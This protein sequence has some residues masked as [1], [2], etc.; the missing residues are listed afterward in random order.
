MLSYIL[1]R[2]LP[3]AG[4]PFLDYYGANQ[5]IPVTQVINRAHFERRYYLYRTLGLFGYGSRSAPI[6]V[7][8][9][10]AGTGDNAVATSYF[11]PGMQI[12]FIDGN[13]ASY[14][15]IEEKIKSNI[16]PNTSS[17][18]CLDFVSADL[19]GHYKSYDL[20]ICEGTIPGQLKPK[21]F[22]AK[23]FAMAGEQG[24][25]CL[26]CADSFS[27][28]P[29]MLRRLYRPRL[30]KYK[31][32]E[33][34]KRGVQI[35]ETHL[36]A[37]PKMSRAPEDWVVDQII[38]PWMHENWE[39]SILDAIDVASACGFDF[40]GSSPSFLT[41][42]S[43][44][45]EVTETKNYWNRIASDAW[46]RKRIYS[47]SKSL[48]I[49][50]KDI[51][52]EAQLSLLMHELSRHVSRISTNDQHVYCES[53]YSSV[54]YILKEIR[55]VLLASSLRDELEEVIQAI[56]DFILAWPSIC[57]GDV[58]VDTNSFKTWWGRGQ[59]YVSFQRWINI[60][61]L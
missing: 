21:E 58:L 55:K 57:F 1:S 47:I 52:N 26:T 18:E 16:L 48:R 15:A 32:T 51:D 49:S 46:K 23:L 59:Q 41:D 5:I 17:L 36:D 13:Q 42:W 35:F 19:S 37:L 50:D 12:S 28:L 53:D 30:M 56:S 40:L 14:S 10:G 60:P 8:E 2:S 34:V 6:K 29:E 27:L 54:G 9:I 31:Y 20:V 43:W 61:V 33:A 11:M 22:A 39:F 44:Y 38:H 4:K 24:R 25:V 7:M 3:V 45:K